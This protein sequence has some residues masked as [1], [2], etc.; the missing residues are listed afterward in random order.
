[1]FAL[2]RFDKCLWSVLG[3][4]LLSWLYALDHL[5]RHVDPA[6]HA[7]TLSVWSAASSAA[8]WDS[9]RRTTGSLTKADLPAVLAIYFPQY[10]PDPLND[11]LWEPN[12]TDWNSLQ[13]APE[14]NRL[15]LKIPR[16]LDGT[17]YDLRDTAGRKRQ[18]ELARQYGIDGFVI[19]H[20]WFYD[21]THPG[22]NLHAPLQAMLRDGEP[23]VPFLFNWC[24]STW[25]SQWTGKA[26][27]EANNRPQILQEQYWNATVP[28]LRKHYEWL[29]QF[30]LLPNYIRI[31]NQ[32]VLM[33]YQYF[34]QMK[35]MLQQFRNWA[36][37]DPQLTGLVIWM[38]R[39]ATHPDLYDISAADEATQRVWK[40]RSQQREL[41]PTAASR[42]DGFV[43][44]AT[45]AYPYPHPWVNRALQLPAWC[46]D[47]TAR[48]EDP[49]LGALREIPGVVTS[50]DNTP[51]RAL[52]KALIWNV[53]KDPN[54]VIQRF[55]DS[56]Y[57]AV[58]YQ[59]CCRPQ[60][61]AMATSRFVIINAWNEWAEAM[62]MEPSD[63]YG[64]GFLQAVKDVKEKILRQG[65]RP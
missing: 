56:M 38:S 35:H 53:E 6:S 20:Y 52:D 36:T 8:A 55:A 13:A 28:E 4:S 39:S 24:A 34:P 62:A 63:V 58:Y 33:I 7:S 17:Y 31:Q 14:K 27:G 65:C 5:S 47:P 1:M 11:R 25:T 2:S 9:P 29:R 43:W 22:P 26:A 30:W 59:T 32:P 64:T 49:S 54:R 37:Q 10:H 21:P 41:L 15:G 16:P 51:R 46:E 61:T 48:L 12:F 44:N 45:V 18:G 40:R 23:A 19:H 57:A 42:H 50:F 60:T 3:W